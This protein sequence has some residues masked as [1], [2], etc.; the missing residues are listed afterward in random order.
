MIDLHCH[1]FPSVDDGPGAMAEALELARIAVDNGIRRAVVTPHIHPG[2][3]DNDF[4][5]IEAAWRGFSA[6][7]ADHGIALE[8]SFAAEVRLDI[9]ILPMVEAGRIPFL[10]EVD[11]FRILLLEF[12]HGNIPVGSD[13]L[14]RW[15]LDR[16][17]RPVIA[18][19]E[20]NKD[21][22]RDPERLAP[23]VSMGCWTQVTSGSLAGMFGPL[24]EACGLD[25]LERGWVTLI[26]SDAHNRQVRVPALEPGRAVAARIVGEQ[27]SWQLV[28]DRPAA[29]SKSK[30]AP[31]LAKGV[32][33]V[34]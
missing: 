6:A 17:I 12:P 4:A 33:P 7:L 10:G 26:A 3:Y 30:F 29:I 8:V 27:E 28:R 23:F 31:V 13:R 21:V 19:P 2:Q 32:S 9:E 15:L 34:R 20:R 22:M 16:K 24:V 18:H 5:S 25:L 14:V 1:L 11:G